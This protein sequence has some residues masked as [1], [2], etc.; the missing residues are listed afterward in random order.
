MNILSPTLLNGALAP[1][2]RPTNMMARRRTLCRTFL[3]FSMLGPQSLISRFPVSITAVR[4]CDDVTEREF[5]R[6]ER[7]VPITPEIKRFFCG[8]EKGGTCNNEHFQIV[9]IIESTSTKAVGNLIRKILKWEG[10]PTTRICVKMLQGAPS[11]GCVPIK[12]RGKKPCTPGTPGT[13]RRCFLY[14]VVKTDGRD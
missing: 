9:A 14:F 11:F 12:F 13:P 8:K 3:I 2:S 1:L 5:K 7:A 6:L 10:D 4:C